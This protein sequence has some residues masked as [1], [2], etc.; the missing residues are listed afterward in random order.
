[1]TGDVF[2]ISTSLKR[3]SLLAHE[4]LKSFFI[5]GE[6]LEPFLQPCGQSPCC[7]G[8]PFKPLAPLF[9]AASSQSQGFRYHN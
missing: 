8:A 5:V 9:G 7:L 6:F 2:L 1:M 4:Q 3:A